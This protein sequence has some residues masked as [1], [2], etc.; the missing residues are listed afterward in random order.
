MDYIEPTLNASITNFVILAFKIGSIYKQ[1][2][3]KHC[4]IMSNYTFLY[5]K[6]MCNVS[7]PVVKP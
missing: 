5:N 7:F 2:S 1:M 4:F 6:L 3:S